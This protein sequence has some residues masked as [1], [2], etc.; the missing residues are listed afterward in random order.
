LSR[1][2]Q[3]AESDCSARWDICAH[4]RGFRNINHPFQSSIWQVQAA[5]PGAGSPQ[6]EP[7]Q[8]ML[9]CAI[10]ICRTVLSV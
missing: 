2:I 4:C 10:L 8:P 1:A 6:W 7:S 9:C 3:Q 5:T